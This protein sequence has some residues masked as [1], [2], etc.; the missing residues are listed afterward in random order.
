MC[1]LFQTKRPFITL[2]RNFIVIGKSYNLKLNRRQEV[3]QES[4]FHCSKVEALRTRTLMPA[5]ADKIQGPASSPLP[6]PTISKVKNTQ[7]RLSRRTRWRGGTNTG[8]LR[9]WAHTETHC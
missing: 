4:N 3:F 7:H 1:L 5:I 9:A 2:I 8:H 6:H